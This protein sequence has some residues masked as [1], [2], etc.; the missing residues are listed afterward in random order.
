MRSFTSDELDKLIAVAETHNSRD[1]MLIRVAYNH[2]LRVNEAVNLGPENL[3]GDTLDVQRLKGS[4]HTRQTMT[5][6]ERDYLLL[7]LPAGKPFKMHRT[8][9]SRKLKKYGAEAGIDLSKCHPHTLKHTCGRLAHEAGVSIPDLQQILG[10]V[11][12][13]N[14]LRYM[15]ADPDKA[16]NNFTTKVSR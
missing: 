2:G 14:T 16:Y 13:G 9:L 15:E 10:H 6:G 5:P 1:A 11:D 12:P 3:A 7:N 8:T 4:M